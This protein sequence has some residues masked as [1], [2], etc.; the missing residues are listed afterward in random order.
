[1]RLVI[2]SKGQVNCLLSHRLPNSL[3]MD[4]KSR[5]GTLQ[6]PHPLAQLYYAKTCI[7]RFLLLNMDTPEVRDIGSSLE[8]FPSSV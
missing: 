3:V 7:L 8:V 2:R 1:M 5:W 6:R 4:S